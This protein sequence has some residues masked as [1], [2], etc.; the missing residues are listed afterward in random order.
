M[1]HP[2]PELDS[3]FSWTQ[4][5]R[6]D[7]LVGDTTAIMTQRDYELLYDYSRSRPS[8]AYPGK[9][10]KSIDSATGKSYLH[11]YGLVPGNPNLVSNNCREIVIGEWKTLFGLDSKPD[12]V[13]IA[14]HLL[15]P[16]GKLTLKDH[17][18]KYT[19]T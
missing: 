4:P 10:W 18:Y 2:I 13:S 8:G 17:L 14:K 9:M 1:N 7:I 11:W 6:Q 19:G 15:Y 3:P 5:D 16:P 12:W